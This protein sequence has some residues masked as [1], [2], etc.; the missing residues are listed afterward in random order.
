MSDQ[1]HIRRQLSAQYGLLLPQAE[2]DIYTPT[3]GGLTSNGVTTYTTQQGN[4]RLIGDVCIAQFELTW[5]NATGTGA[6]YISLPFPASAGLEF[7]MAVY[8]TNITF[9]GSGIVALV[10]TGLNYLVLGTLTSNG[11]TATLPVETAGTVF[12]TAIYFVG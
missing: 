4:Y 5:T 10:N 3:Y 12:G 11:A 9:G 1:D 6:A 7:A 2:N 8:P